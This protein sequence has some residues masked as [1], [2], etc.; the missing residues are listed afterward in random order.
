VDSYIFKPARCIPKLDKVE[1]TLLFSAA[2]HVPISM[3]LTI[4]N[5]KCY[6]YNLITST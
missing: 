4:D 3:T 6:H 5:I 2:S 1:E